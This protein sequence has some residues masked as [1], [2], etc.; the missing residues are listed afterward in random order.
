VSELL[1]VKLPLGPRD[2][3]VTKLQA[4]NMGSYHPGMLQCLEVELLL[5][6]VGLAGYRVHTQGLIR[7][8]AQT[9]KDLCH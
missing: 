3:G 8:P 9:G 7:A 2:S 5:R 6:F 4:G 1:G